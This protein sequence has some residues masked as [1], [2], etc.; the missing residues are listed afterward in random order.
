[1]YIYIYMFPFLPLSYFVN[2]MLNMGIVLIC[3]IHFSIIS[4][5][6]DSVFYFL[7][8]IKQTSVIKSY[9][10]EIMIRRKEISLWENG[11]PYKVNLSVGYS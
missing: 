9:Y 11:L 3:I 6:N 1:M 5:I 2:F 10:A 7:A 8:G 4:I